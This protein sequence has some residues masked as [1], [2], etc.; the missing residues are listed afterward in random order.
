AVRP[1]TPTCRSTPWSRR[2]VSCAP[3]GG[4][5]RA[6]GRH[7]A[8]DRRAGGGVLRGTDAASG[9]ASALRGGEAAA[10]RGGRG[11]GEFGQAPGGP[12]GQ[13]DRRQGA[14]RSGG[15]AEGA[16]GAAGTAGARDG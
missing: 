1:A 9:R 4:N 10:D 14:G 11:G 13:G 5:D 12:G 16:P 7:L 8:A 2:R 6:A 15:R 3:R